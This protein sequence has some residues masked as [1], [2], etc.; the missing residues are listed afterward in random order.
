MDYDIFGFIGHNDQLVCFNISPMSVF[1]SK[2]NN[3]QTLKYDV[4]MTSPVAKHIT[5]GTLVSS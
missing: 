4:S 3:I 1:N 2:T 5:C